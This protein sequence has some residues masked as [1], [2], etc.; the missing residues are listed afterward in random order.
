MDYLRR[1]LSRSRERQRPTALSSSIFNKVP[2]DILVHIMD[3]LPSES[4]VASSLSCMHLKCLL[5]TQHFSRVTSSTKNTLALLN[6]LVL[7]LPNDV[8]C[9][10]CTRLHNM[11]NLLRYN[12]V[13]YS[14]NST[15]SQY[16]SLRLPA[17]VGQDWNKKAY[18][19]TGLIGTTAFKMAIK[20]YHQQPECTKLL[21]IMSSKEAKI[22]KTGDYVRQFREECRVVQGCLMH[23][24][25][26]VHVLRQ[27]ST[28][29]RFRRNAPSE[30]IYHMPTYL[31]EL[32][33]RRVWAREMSRMPHRIPY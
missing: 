1:P 16:N 29:T 19:I 15:T 23:R 24:L 21:K 10:V 20:R 5:G 3:Y 33:V 26:S 4:A 7:D 13:T 18:A 12:C 11:E 22:M 6:L 27:C 8:V 9:S 17:C 32:D 31:V 14:A 30:R 2:V 25:Q 28:T